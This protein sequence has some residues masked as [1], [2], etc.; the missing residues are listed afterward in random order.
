MPVRDQSKAEKPRGRWF[1][2]YDE[3]LDEPK[4]QLLSPELFK[5]WINILALASRHRG[6]LPPLSA[7]AFSLRMSP[8]EMQSKLDELVLAGLIDVMPDKSLEPHN[9]SS[10]QWASDD[11]KERVRE[12]RSRKKQS[13]DVTAGNGDVTVT[14]TPPDTDTDTE[15]EADN[16]PPAGL[17]PAGGRAEPTA[18]KIPNGIPPTEPSPVETQLARL[19]GSGPLIVAGLARALAVPGI[20]DGRHE[21]EIVIA[22]NVNVHGPEAVKRAWT[23]LEADLG[24]GK[25]LKAGVMKT[26]AGYA[27]RA[28]EGAIRDAAPKPK[29]KFLAALER[30]EARGRA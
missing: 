17:D 25:T 24:D 10:R 22:G 14:V 30:V 4:V 8:T 18:I 12:H 6:K 27:R 1:R 15:T 2:M 21:A 16:S 20:R 29:S 5:A 28:A 3:M 7:M 19:N 26:F 13:T 9:W 11:S 23:D